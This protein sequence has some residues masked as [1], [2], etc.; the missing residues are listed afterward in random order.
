MLNYLPNYQ[1]SESPF[2]VMRKQSSACYF[3]PHLKCRFHLP[4]ISSLETTT[5][6]PCLIIHLIRFLGRF[7]FD[8]VCRCDL[9]ERRYNEAWGSFTP[10]YPTPSLNIH[11]SGAGS[12]S[13]G[14]VPIKLLR[15]YYSSTSHSVAANVP[16]QNTHN[17]LF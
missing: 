4:I 10:H 2:L 1:V 8:F 13:Y 16:S 15:Q 14:V 5:S 12:L 3:C 6:Q 7:S 17:Y 9:A 11:L